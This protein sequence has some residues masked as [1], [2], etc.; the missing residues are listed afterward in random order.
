MIDITDLLQE[1]D[2]MFV[3]GCTKEA[4]LVMVAF[5]LITEDT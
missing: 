5:R 1:E 2:E 4:G 3:Q